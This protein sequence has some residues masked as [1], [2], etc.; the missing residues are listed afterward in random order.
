MRKKAHNLITTHDTHHVRD[1]AYGIVPHMADKHHMTDHVAD[2][3]HMRDTATGLI[4]H[5]AE[6]PPYNG[7]HGLHPP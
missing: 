4:P 3:H 7:S 6:N 1:N 2:T 5:V